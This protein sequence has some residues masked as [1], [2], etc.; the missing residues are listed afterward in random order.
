MAWTAI[1]STQT[2][3]GSP[4]DQTLMDAIRTNLDDLDTRVD[5]VHAHSTNHIRDDFACSTIDTSVWDT[6]FLGGGTANIDGTYEHTVIVSGV[7]N[8]AVVAAAAG[9]MR[10][11]IAE[12]RT[13]VME[14]RIRHAGG[15]VGGFF[16]GAQDNGLT[17]NATFTSDIS[18]C[19]GVHI[20]NANQ[21][22]YRQALAG[23]ATQSV[24]FASTA[25]WQI[26]KIT[27]TCSATSGNRSVEVLLNGSAISGSPFT[28]NL[29]TARLRPCIAE[30]SGGGLVCDYFLAYDITRPIAP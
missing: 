30:T 16:I 8:Y 2:D 3:S 21:W 23:A 28:T 22:T 18:D 14:F 6:A 20:P 17:M 1:S 7:A 15:A 25:S 13:V 26:V 11:D 10:F 27:I 24:D 4:V 19:I 29:P 9:K 12:A 5:S